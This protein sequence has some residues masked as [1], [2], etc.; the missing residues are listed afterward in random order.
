VVIKNKLSFFI[1]FFISFGLLAG[2]LWMMRGD[3]GNVLDIIKKSNK[4]F[5]IL[6]LCVSMPLSPILAYRLKILMKGQKIFL[7]M[8]D[9]L[10]LTYIGYFF[11]NFLPTAVGGDIVKAYY[12]SKKTHN[13]IGSYAAV[14][15][16]R[17]LGVVALLFITLTGIIFMGDKFKND[18]IFWT[19]IGAS[20]IAIV[21]TGI[22]LNKKAG[23]NNA[24]SA[25]PGIMAKIVAN[26]SKVR[27]AI[28]LYRNS[29]KILTKALL[30]SFLGQ[31]GA[32]VSIYFFVLFLGGYVPLVKLFLIVP[33]VWAISMLPSLNG[34][35]VREG[36]FVYFL[37]GDIGTDAAFAVSILWLGVIIVYSII[38]GLLNLFFPVEIKETTEK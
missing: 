37:K 32:I 20:G 5:L 15:A 22:L 3:I 14:L 28:S 30:I 6:A 21:V 1:R 25:K 33:L 13:K 19:I 9:L 7:S 17:L 23:T 4:I 2:L 35:G 34:L 38:G 31:A 29:P 18:K 16:D 12:A 24:G 36:A 8:K 27:D 11:N 10:Y 26:I